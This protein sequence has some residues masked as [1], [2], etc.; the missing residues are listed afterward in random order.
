MIEIKKR[1]NH[2]RNGHD[3]MKK[4]MIKRGRKGGW[5]LVKYQPYPDNIQKNRI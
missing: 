4:H 3:K 5:M 1:L 2:G